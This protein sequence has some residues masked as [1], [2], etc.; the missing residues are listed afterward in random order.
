MKGIE[1]KQIEAPY[2]LPE[3]WKWINILNAFENKTSSNKKLPTNEYCETGSFAVIDQGQN[4][5]GGYSDR[6][7][8]VFDGELPVIVFGDHTKCIK[9]IDFAFI[10]GADGIK[11]LK[12][13]KTIDGK[14]FYYGLKSI[15]FPDLGYRR[16]FPI[17]KNYKFPLPPTLDEQQRIVDRIESMFAKLDEA[18]EK[19][20]NVVDG[21]EIRKAAILHKA[22]TGE[23]TA[24]WRKENGVSDDSWVEK[25]IGEICL[26]KGGKRVPKG[27]SLI[28]EK[29]EHP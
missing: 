9:F 10:Q 28:K 18:K 12:P 4:F 13:I 20:Q 1:E 24:K 5:I 2:E 15:N 6:S 19:A 16:H 11:V 3:G 25:T 17:F 23:L 22:F 7:E 8:L 27:M 14:Y 29:N 26:V 21:F